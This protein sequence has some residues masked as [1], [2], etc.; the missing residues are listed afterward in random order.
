MRKII[1]TDLTRF[2]N[3]EIVCTAGIDINNG[4]CVRPMPYLKYSYCKELNLLPS[5]I[6]SG[7]FSASTSIE[8]PHTEDMHHEN[9]QFHGHCSD[10]EFRDVL[11][12]SCSE[13]IECGFNVQLENRQ[14]HIPLELAPLKSI[15]TISVNPNTVKIVQDQYDSKKIKIHFTDNNFKE[16]SF[17][18]IT[19][20]GFH[21]YAENHYKET[22]NYNEINSVIKNQKEVFL[23]IGLG[24]I[25]TSQQN[26]T[27][28]W[29]QV[30][31]IYSFPD[32]FKS[33]RR[34]E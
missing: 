10:N 28:F 8:R 20:L 29:I 27:G 1:I 25:H 19:D 6:L 17:L 16:Y 22:N 14:K 18:S 13:N 32:Y 21:S 33:A 24:R 3:R 11:L 34:Y 5:A 30:N 12:Q 31:G 7:N 4:E 2:S 26:K 23:R 9:L 15:I